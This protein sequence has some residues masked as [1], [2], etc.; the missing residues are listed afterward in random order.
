MKVVALIAL[1]ASSAAFA[2]S[3][4]WHTPATGYDVLK[5]LQRGMTFRTTKRG[6]IEMGD[7]AAATGFILGIAAAHSPLCFP[8]RSISSDQAKIVVRAYLE[9]NTERLGEPAPALITA[10]LEKAFPCRSAQPNGTS[11]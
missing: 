4:R 6:L 10:A 1:L 9:Q 3:A 8:G 11:G 5:Q 2:Q 7:Y